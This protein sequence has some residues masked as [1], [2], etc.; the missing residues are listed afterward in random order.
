MCYNFIHVW[1]QNIPHLDRKNQ[2]EKYIT[3][4]IYFYVD[5]ECSNIFPYHAVSGDEIQH[6]IS[7]I[8]AWQNI[9]FAMTKK[10]FRKMYSGTFQYWHIFCF[11]NRN[12][13]V[14][15]DIHMYMWICF[16]LTPLT[17][18]SSSLGFFPYIRQVFLVGGVRAWE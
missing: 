6:N 13:Y 4:I 16:L 7:A 17:Y 1:N 15:I 12:M 10:V 9:F 11:S 2:V 3:Y 14:K 18:L 8:Y 5:Q